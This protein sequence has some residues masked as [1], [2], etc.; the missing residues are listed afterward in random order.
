MEKPQQPTSITVKGM[1]SSDVII[2]HVPTGYIPGYELQKIADIE[3]GHLPA[4]QQDKGSTS[5]QCQN[6]ED[7]ETLEELRRN[8]PEM[9]ERIVNKY[10]FMDDIFTLEKYRLRYG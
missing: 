7:A 9:V 4:E 2:R 5:T 1:I 3:A 6:E 8:L 10:Y